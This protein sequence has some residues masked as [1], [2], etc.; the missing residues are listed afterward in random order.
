MLQKIGDDIA[1]CFA[2]ATDADRRAAEASSEDLR[3]DYERIAQTWRHLASS[4]QFVESLEPA[5]LI[6]KKRRALGHL[7]A[8]RCED[9]PPI[10]SAGCHIRPRSR[11]CVGLCLSVG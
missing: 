3:I 2:R 10:S 5:C 4:Y 8:N 11:R 1:N 7:S 9:H 6:P